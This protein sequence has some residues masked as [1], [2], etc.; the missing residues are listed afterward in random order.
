MEEN[1]K[2]KTKY[3]YVPI[4]YKNLATTKK[5]NR[6]INQKQNRFLSENRILKPEEHS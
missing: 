2:M 5:H 3:N 1:W 4:K 6:L